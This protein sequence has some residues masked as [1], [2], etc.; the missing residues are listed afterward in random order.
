MRTILSLFSRRMTRLLRPN[1]RPLLRCEG[2]EDRL[3]PAA[4]STW[5]AV[6]VN[7]A[8]RTRRTPRPW[9]RELCSRRGSKSASPIP[10]EKRAVTTAPGLWLQHITTREPDGAQLEVAGA[11]LRAALNIEEAQPARAA[12]PGEMLKGI[13]VN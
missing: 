11:A 4:K 8:E 2:L 5:A 7:Y 9:R 12:V 1:H 3:A 6:L 10:P 13:S